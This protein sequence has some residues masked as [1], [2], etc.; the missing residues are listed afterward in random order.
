MRSSRVR[1]TR[2]KR[3]RSASREVRPRRCRSAKVAGVIPEANPAKVRDE[4]QR[5]AVFSAIA[6]KGAPRAKCGPAA[7]GAQRLQESSPKPVR[8]K[9]ATRSSEARFSARLR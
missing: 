4:I 7:A 2:C 5:G 9:F 3:I 6:L 8:R 1:F